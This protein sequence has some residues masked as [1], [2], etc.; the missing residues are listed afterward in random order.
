[1]SMMG[2][3]E[4]SMVEDEVRIIQNNVRT[5]LLRKNYINLRD[6]AKTLQMAWREKRNEKYQ[7]VHKSKKER[8][9]SMSELDTINETSKLDSNNTTYHQQQQSLQSS[10]LHHQQ[11]KYQH[12]LEQLQEQD[13]QNYHSI[14]VNSNLT[15]Y[16]Q[17]QTQNPH[18]TLTNNNLHD[19]NNNNN[20]SQRISNDKAAST[21]QA[22]TRGMLARKEFHLIKRQTMA[23]LVIQKSLLQWWIQKGL[24]SSHESNFESNL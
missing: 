17:S 21:L 10:Q 14:T 2:P 16:N 4:L 20:S 11:E 1:M 23:S 13:H 7:Q 9:K 18:D 6:A 15:S 24:S 3:Q 5:W 12:Q 22:I 19:Q 8:K